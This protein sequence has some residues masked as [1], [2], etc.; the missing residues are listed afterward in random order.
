[1]L[2]SSFRDLSHV[3]LV[4]YYTS[5]AAGLLWLS[6]VIAIFWAFKF[7]FHWKNRDPKQRHYIHAGMVVTSLL[8]PWITIGIILGIEE[9][10]VDRFPPIVCHARN[11]DVTF[12]GYIL[13][14][15]TILLVGI[16][17]LLLVFRVLVK[18]VHSHV[19]RMSRSKRVCCVVT[20]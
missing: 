1:M 11:V 15:S 4:F 10:Q 20:Q 16:T 6:H 3:G 8:L 2:V 19:W 12:Y 9:I 7:P 14:I 18:H 13:P 5:M 17:L